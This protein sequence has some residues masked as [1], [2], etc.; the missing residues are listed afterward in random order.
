M[1]I[2]DRCS[3]VCSSDLGSDLARVR[4]LVDAP[5][6]AA[7]ELEMLDRVGDVGCGAVDAGVRERL[8][9]DAA[10]WPDD[11]TAGDRKSVVSGMRVSVR[12]AL[13]GRRLLQ[14]TSMH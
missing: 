13:G 8:V 12:S 6:A 4:L 7:L 2:S 14:Q 9:E 3:D 5:L 1:L 10:G 11:G